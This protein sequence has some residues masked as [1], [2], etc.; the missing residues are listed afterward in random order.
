MAIEE[1]ALLT[2]LQ[3]HKGAPAKPMMLVLGL[4]LCVGD[5]ACISTAVS[6]ESSKAMWQCQRPQQLTSLQG[7][8]AGKTADTP[9]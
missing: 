5:K 7:T 8:E 3:E 1:E 2:S 9:W 6:A 4:A